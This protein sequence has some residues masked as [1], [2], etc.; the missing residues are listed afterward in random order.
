MKKIKKRPVVI[1]FWDHTSFT[2]AVEVAELE[3]VEAVGYLVKETELAYIVVSWTAGDE[4]DD[5]EGFCIFKPAI[6]EMRY[7]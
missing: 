4:L 3:P 5:T 2:G 7:L 1:R 6:I